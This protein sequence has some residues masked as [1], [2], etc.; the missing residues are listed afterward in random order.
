[1]IDD[2]L[3]PVLDFGI[4]YGKLDRG[5]IQNEQLGRP[6]QVID[7]HRQAPFH[8]QIAVI[9]K[10]GLHFEMLDDHM[11]YALLLLFLKVI[12]D[13]HIFVAIEILIKIEVKCPSG[14][15]FEVIDVV[16]PRIYLI[17][18]DFTVFQRLPWN[19]DY[20]LFEIL[21][22]LIKHLQSFLLG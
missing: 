18:K 15:L 13:V 6:S 21:P 8:Y 19:V 3:A 16:K 20:V 5:L 10:S 7:A 14:Y 1:M 17:V 4:M 2:M 11:T 12:D 22:N 9:T